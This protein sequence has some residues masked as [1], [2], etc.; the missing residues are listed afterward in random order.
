MTADRSTRLAWAVI[1]MAAALVAAG[2]VGLLSWWSGLNEP[3]ALMS[4]MAS[5]SGAATFGFS[6]FDFIAGRERTPRVVNSSFRSARCTCQSQQ[7]H[8]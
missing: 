1:I 2:T 6:T 4:A 5:F 7:R 3:Q 8:L